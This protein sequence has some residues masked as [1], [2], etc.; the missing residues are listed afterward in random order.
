VSVSFDCVE[1][2]DGTVSV[3]AIL[4]DYFLSVG[5]GDQTTSNARKPSLYLLLLVRANIPMRLARGSKHAY[6][7]TLKGS[8]TN[9][10]IPYRFLSLLLLLQTRFPVRLAW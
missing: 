4:V 1:T 6:D 2:V 9:I 8:T 3:Q 7:A 10:S 5:G